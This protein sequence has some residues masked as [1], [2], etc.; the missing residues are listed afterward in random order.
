MLRDRANNVKS[1]VYGFKQ[2]LKIGNAYSELVGLPVE[3]TTIV[4]G[5]VT[6]SKPIRKFNLDWVK[7]DQQNRR[8]SANNTAGQETTN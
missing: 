1:S 8:P 3:T 4:G 5:V 6:T 2:C 7:W